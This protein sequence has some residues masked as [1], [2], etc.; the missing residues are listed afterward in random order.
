MK[1]LE[2]KLQ[3]SRIQALTPV[4]MDVLRIVVCHY[5]FEEVLLVMTKYADKEGWTRVVALLEEAAT[6]VE[7]EG[8]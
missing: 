8:R 4:I 2:E 3:E 6:E 7:K 1:E 5:G